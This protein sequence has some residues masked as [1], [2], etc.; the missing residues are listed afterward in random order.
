MP[1]LA[2]GRVAPPVLVVP[3]QWTGFDAMTWTDWTGATFDLFGSGDVMV[4]R[5]GLRGLNM[6][7]Y[8]RYT[9]ESP[10]VPGSSYRGFRTKERTVFW[11]TMV[12]STL[13]ADDFLV[14]DR[15]LWQGMRPDQVG[16]WAVT[17]RGVTRTLT[18]RYTGDGDQVTNGD[19]VQRGW[20]L[21]GLNF[22]A[23][24]PYW[25]GDPVTAL[26]SN[27]TTTATFFDTSRTIGSSFTLSSAS[28]S[29]TGDVP[30]FPVWTVYGPCTTAT[31]TINGQVI[32]VPITLTAGQRLTI[33]TDPS[34]LTAIRETGADVTGQL[35]SRGFAPIQPGTTVPLGLAMTGNG[36]VAVALT[37]QF[38]RCY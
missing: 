19:P 10:A 28:V 4:M 3:D 30:A 18:L 23:E 29:N 21:Y 33:D 38:Y 35:G 9:N 32:G 17:V 8:D 16:Q 2:V 22:V 14:A 12:R 15:A 5:D 13:S 7:P 24:E 27:A 1:I 25:S 20:E 11:P 37:P 6:P 36:A 31:I 34:A 26:F